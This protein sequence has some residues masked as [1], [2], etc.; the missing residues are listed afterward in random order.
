MIDFQF[1]IDR[2]VTQTYEALV[3]KSRL[4]TLQRVANMT[5]QPELM[6]ALFKIINKTVQ[7]TVEEEE[8]IM[9]IANRL[10]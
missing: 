2:D 6:M 9:S 1:G 7:L 4:D 10:V 5:D 8:S 3:E